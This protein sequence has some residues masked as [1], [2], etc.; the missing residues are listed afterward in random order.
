MEDPLQLS[1]FAQELITAENQFNAQY[2]EEEEELQEYSK[3]N[4]QH[5]FEQIMTQK[6]KSE[7]PVV[8]KDVRTQEQIYAEC[9]FETA[10]KSFSD[11][12]QCQMSK[13]NK[14][15]LP[16]SVISEP[17]F[18]FFGQGKEMY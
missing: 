2:G 16:H 11:F 18:S 13:K 5:V 8:A 6:P 9:N 7:T 12:M 4:T 3:D 17:N 14:L 10:T 15:V 1:T